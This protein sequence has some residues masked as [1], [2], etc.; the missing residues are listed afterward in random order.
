[1]IRVLIFLL[2][3]FVSKNGQAQEVNSS[4]NSISLYR[5]SLAQ[6]SSAADLANGLG[7]GVLFNHQLAINKSPLKTNDLGLRFFGSPDDGKNLLVN[8]RWNEVAI[9]SIL[10]F[11]MILN[12]YLILKIVRN[13]QNFT[14][15]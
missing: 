11:S 9:Y 8:Q 2:L 10:F 6:R 1:M 12:V 13:P 5:S 14:I 3:T 7:S 4:E 15:T